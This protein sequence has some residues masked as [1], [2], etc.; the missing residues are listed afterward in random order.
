[1]LK[2][3]L[4]TIFAI[5]MLLAVAL[6][7][8]LWYAN[9]D[10]GRTAISSLA[11]NSLGRDVQYTGNIAL[12]PSW[13]LRVR[14][15]GLTIDNMSNGRANN[16]VNLGTAEVSIRLL[17]LLAGKVHLPYIFVDD[18]EI[19]LERTEQKAN[20]QFKDTPPEENT[21]SSLK[22]GML[23]IQDTQLT[24][25][26]VPQNIDLAVKAYTE[27]DSI[28]ID[29][30][31]T[32]LGKKFTLAAKG[33][34][35]LSAR[36]DAA[37]PINITAKIGYT[38]IEAKGTI[39]NPTAFS[40]ID[41]NLHLK[42]ADAAELF[43]L[44]GIALPPTPPYDINGK[45]S[46]ANNV[47][48]FSDFTGTMGQSDINGDVKWDRSNARPKLTANFLSKKLDLQ[49]LGP[50]IGLAPQ[51]PESTQQKDLAGRVEESSY[52]IPDVPL[53]ITRVAAMDADVTYK[54]ES[55]VSPYLPLDDFTLNVTLDNSLLHIDPLK[56]GTADG[57]VIATMRVNAREKPVAIDSTF[58]FSRLSLARLTES[59]NKTLPMT[60]KS[61]GMIGGTAKLSGHGISLKEMLSNANGNVGIGM[62]GGQISNLL[63]ELIG[64]DIAQGLG[65][66]IAGDEVVPVRC[67]I[68]DFAVNDGI[69]Q[70]RAVVIDTADT[71]I[72]GKGTINLKSEALD[73]IIV[74]QP[75]DASIVTLR[76]PLRVE[77]TLKNPDFVIEKGRLLAKGAGAIAL[78]ALLTPAASL[79]AL[80]EAGLGED[81]NCA[82]LVNS[83]NA[84]NNTNAQTDNVP[85]NA[86]A[87]QDDAPASKTAQQPDAPKT[88]PSDATPTP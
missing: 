71:N 1:M 81:S 56:F 86:N 4:V 39:E 6:G 62:E 15:Q 10:N 22:L 7:Y 8:G 31:G 43:P 42:G 17:P 20:W 24:Y 68:G 2:K 32:Y 84:H 40:G 50:L 25:Y 46:Y 65:F 85:Q 44:F 53:D 29:G 34:E 11:T 18:S 57:D 33:G 30:K 27:K 69:M 41:V 77:G 54:G 12:V 55:V 72:Q 70:S 87:P 74:P 58:E 78:G 14:L 88:D 63:V 83:M 37:Y 60:E 49:D 26:D 35:L 64:L 45:L 67:I 61:E 23:E 5:C 75:K 48:S 79:L 76:V 16:M 82:A 19:H 80:A 51:D 47:W 28:I 21:P 52:L 13:P 59:A 3:I 36:S 66:F 38:T 9:T 73:L